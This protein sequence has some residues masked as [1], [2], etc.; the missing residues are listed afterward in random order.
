RQLISRDLAFGGLNT[1]WRTTFFQEGQRTSRLSAQFTNQ[2]IDVVPGYL[3]SRGSDVQRPSFRE[4][5]FKKASDRPGRR[6]GA[7][8]QNMWRNG[9]GISACAPCGVVLKGER[10]FLGIETHC[11][12]PGDSG[13]HRHPVLAHESI[14][15][16]TG[17]T[18]L[19]FSLSRTSM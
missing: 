10:F 13:K 19:S 3:V 12:D 6:G 2:S 11:A 14:R 17:T 4:Q 7:V 1:L 16:S 15:S 9:K 18:A 5:V 8:N